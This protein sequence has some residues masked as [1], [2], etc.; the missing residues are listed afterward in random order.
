MEETMENGTPLVLWDFWVGDLPES[1]MCYCGVGGV[2]GERGGPGVGD[3]P[4]SM[5]CYRGVGGVAGER[6]SPRAGDLPESSVQLLLQ[7]RQDGL[8]GAH[9]QGRAGTL[10]FFFFSSFFP[11]FFSS[12]F[13]SNLPGTTCGAFNQENVY[14]CNNRI[15]L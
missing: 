11:S 10:P 1:M 5:M 14:P 12:F 4:E 15:Q 9:S 7:L 6:G 13:S 2:A 3:L 8:R